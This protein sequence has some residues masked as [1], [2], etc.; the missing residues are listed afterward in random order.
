MTGTRLKPKRMLLWSL[1]LSLA[2]G[3]GISLDPIAQSGLGRAVSGD[4]KRGHLG[5]REFHFASRAPTR[6]Q[7]QPLKSAVRGIE[8]EF[9]GDRERINIVAGEL[10]L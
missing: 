1:S 4:Q 5:C 10:P 3:N 7:S 9:D 2:L 6:V 8:G